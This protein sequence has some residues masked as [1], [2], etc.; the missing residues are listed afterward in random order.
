[1][2]IHTD[3]EAQTK[4][5]EGKEENTKGKVLN[6]DVQNHPTRRKQCSYFCLISRV[7]ALK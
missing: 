5:E 2:G 4:S 3:V 7:I 6:I 1:M